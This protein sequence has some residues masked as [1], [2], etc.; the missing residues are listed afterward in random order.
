MEKVLEFIRCELEAGL[1]IVTIN[2]PPVNALNKQVLDELQAIF[3]D[4]AQNRDVLAVI[5]TGEGNKAFVAGSDMG[6]LAELTPETG[7]ELDQ[8]HHSTFNRIAD[9]PRPVIC[10]INGLAFGGGT[11]LALA[12]DIRIAAQTAVFA[13]PEVSLG[14][15]PSAGG[16]QRLPRIIPVGIAKELIF[17]GRRLK[18]DEAEKLGLV[19]RVVPNDQ[20]LAVAKEI[21][22]QIAANGPFAVEQAKKA[23]NGGLALPPEQAFDLEVNMGARCYGTTDFQEGVQAFFAKR[24]PKFSGV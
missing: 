13:L 5:V 19:N 20:V 22:R 23:I 10:A 12:C 7:K 14:L 6:G 8:L 2:R 18:A 21:G 17:T 15:I 4:L 11:E 1:A 24:P 9:F 16:T 3:T